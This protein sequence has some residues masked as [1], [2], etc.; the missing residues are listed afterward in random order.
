MDVMVRYMDEFRMNGW[1]L[2]WMSWSDTWSDTWTS[3]MLT[4]M[5]GWIDTWTD[6]WLHGPLAR[7]IYSAGFKTRRLVTTTLS[8]W[9][10]KP[11]DL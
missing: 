1:M 6:G 3:G 5:D 4:W 10:L 9:V 8:K 2:T 11:A 7:S